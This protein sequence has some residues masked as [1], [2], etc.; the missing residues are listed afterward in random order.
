M[1]IATG[2]RL[3]RCGAPYRWALPYPMLW[4]GCSPAEPEMQRC[5]DGSVLTVTLDDRIE[6]SRQVQIAD[7]GNRDVRVVLNSG[8][9]VYIKV[10]AYL[11]G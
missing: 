6:Q 3:A 11:P 2:S 10:A 4:P 8:L 5:R 1:V 7:S 9:M